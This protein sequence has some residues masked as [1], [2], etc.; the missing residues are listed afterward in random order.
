MWT[1]GRVDVCRREAMS[2]EVKHQRAASK[3]NAERRRE[4]QTVSRAWA[5]R[6]SITSRGPEVERNEGRRVESNARAPA[7]LGCVV[8]L[9]GTGCLRRERSEGA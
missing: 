7:H 5:G 3:K 1:D 8:R 2:L 4:A 9:G 6:R